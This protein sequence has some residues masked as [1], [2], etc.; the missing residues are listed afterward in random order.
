MSGPL[1]CAS[2][3]ELLEAVADRMQNTQNSHRGDA[4]A[5][6]CL[7]A[8]ANLGP[9]ILDHRPVPDVVLPDLPEGGVVLDANDAEVYTHAF[10]LAAAV[11]RFLRYGKV[12]EMLDLM[13]GSMTEES[14]IDDL[15]R[16]S[17]AMQ[18]ARI[19]RVAN[20][21]AR[22]ADLASEPAPTGHTS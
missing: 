10:H 21:R 8:L 7:A 4:I 16:T 3:R 20:A 1:D 19:R 22:L 14:V 2:T 15:R 18:A 6:L 17:D 9:G 11:D 5:D 12:A 13:R